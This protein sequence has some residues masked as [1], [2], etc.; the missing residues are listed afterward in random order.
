MKMVHPIDG[1]F[2]VIGSGAITIVPLA[3]IALS[4]IV[5][6]GNLVEPAVIKTDIPGLVGIVIGKQ[7]PVH[8]NADDG[9]EQL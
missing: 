5:A 3:L 2:L 8:I 7:E 1:P 9:G 6:Q 4:K